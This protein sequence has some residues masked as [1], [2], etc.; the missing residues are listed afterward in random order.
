[1]G[2]RRSEGSTILL[3]LHLATTNIVSLCIRLSF[4]GFIIFY[5]FT[6]DILSQYLCYLLY[7]NF[8][9]TYTMYVRI[10]LPKRKCSS[11]MAR[12]TREKITFAGQSVLTIVSHCILSLYPW[13][14]Q[15]PPL[16]LPPAAL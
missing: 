16:A 5:C 2:P 8:A 12:A 3:R 10:C 14:P 15:G 9:G 13:P 4:C 7:F 11:L 6:L 1:M